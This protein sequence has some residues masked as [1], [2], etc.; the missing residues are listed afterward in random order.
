MRDIVEMLRRAVP[1]ETHLVVPERNPPRPVEPRLDFHHGRRPEGV[2]EKF[3]LAGPHDLHRTPG[4]LGQ[5]RGFNRLQIEGLAAKTAA[6]KRC[7]DAHVG[8]R[9]AQRPG[10]FFPRAK[11]I[12]R[13]RPDGRLFSFHMRQRGVGFHRGMGDIGAEIS[14]IQPLHRQRP[15]CVEVPA[16]GDN[17][18]LEFCLTQVFVDCLVVQFGRRR[19]ELGLEFFE[20]VF[21]DIGEL[22]QNRHQIGLLHEHNPGDRP[23]GRRVNLLELGPLRRRPQHAGVEHVGQTDVASVFRPARH[24]VERIPAQERFAD[25]L[26]LRRGLEVRLHRHV[27]LDLL[28]LGQLAVSYFPRQIPRIAHD[29][30]LHHEL[31]DGDEQGGSRHVQQ[32][33]PR[34]CRRRPPDVAKHPR[35]HGTPGP[36]VERAQIGVAHDHVDV[37]DRDIKVLGEHLGQ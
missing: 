3:F 34:F 36:L 17:L 28:S 37:I 20:R 24:F 27:A 5:A 32:H 13:G 14:L 30:V 35:G 15:A 11:G 29:A 4:C 31:C 18:G 33:G 22:V 19:L 6:D 2:V 16:V 7:D 10:D 25:D 12:L 1:G 23:G 8:N 21:R 9:Q 26:E